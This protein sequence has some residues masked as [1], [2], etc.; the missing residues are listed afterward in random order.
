M[1]EMIRV[2]YGLRQPITKDKK[3]TIVIVKCTTVWQ[4]SDIIAVL[5]HIYPKLQLHKNP[6]FIISQLFESSPPYF[7]AHST[8]TNIQKLI[9][10]STSQYV[11]S[12]YHVPPL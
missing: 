11:Q 7:I 8:V 10:Y 2:G 6:A 12:S 1:P 4:V 3:Y 9:S 5:I